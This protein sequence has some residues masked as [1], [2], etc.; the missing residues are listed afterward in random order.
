[1]KQKKQ[2]KKERQMEEW[3]R[4]VRLREGFWK[5]QSDKNREITM[6]A[7]GPVRGYGK[8]RGLPL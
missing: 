1:M 8:D 2:V 4:K 3:I 5:Q 6:R 7:V